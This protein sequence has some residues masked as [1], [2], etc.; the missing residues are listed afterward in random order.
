MDLKK[1][2]LS[3]E[4]ILN[5]E[6]VILAAEKYG[7]NPD[8]VLPMVMGESGFNQNAKSKMDAI[9]LM[10]LMPDTAKSLKV[11]PTDIDQNIDGGMRL[12]KEL[13]DNPKIGNDPYKVIIGY[14]ASTETR[15]KF[16]KSGDINELPEET[17]LH[18][19]N[20]MT[21]YGGDLP[22]PYTTAEKEDQ[23]DSDNAPAYNSNG[24]N[25]SEPSPEEKELSSPVLAGVAGSAI[26][27]T[28]GSVGAGKKVLFDVISAGNNLYNKLGSAPTT[29]PS[30]EMTSG[31]KWAKN[32]AGQNQSSAGSVPEASAE[33]QRSKGQGKVTSRQ[34]KLWG[35]RQPTEPGQLPKSRLEQ[36]SSARA[37]RE[38]EKA[39]AIA[40]QEVE[41][42][43]LAKANTPL[44]RATNYV[45]RVA[46]IP[47]KG[48]LA[49][50]G[51][52]FGAQDAYNRYQQGD[53]PGA[54][55]AGT[56]AV[57]S[58]VAPFVARTV[59]GSALGPLS[60]AIPIGLYARDQMTEMT[61][62]QVNAYKKKM[63]TLGG[64]FNQ[65]YDPNV[66]P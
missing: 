21:H 8:F 34:T 46:N 54:V 63:G 38:A 6:K 45:G 19:D 37:A 20:V 15:N 22:K 18:L 9:G 11:D 40:A 16:M 2:K 39:A 58:A 14:N 61:P 49:G 66:N 7:V 13:I 59:A 62:E 43:A 25:G 30:V 60:V 1:L 44:Q 53:I 47:I 3:D 50:F 42:A 27:A 28:A 57:A 51:A 41:Q 64:L 52:G 31:E 48:A 23:A 36:L 10:Q 56:G 32:W 55:A 29:L 65:E 5:A 4:Q 26:G 12:L 17:V 33:Y 35:P 24:F